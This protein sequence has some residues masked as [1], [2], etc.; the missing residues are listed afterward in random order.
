ML[1]YLLLK[2]LENDVFSYTISSNKGKSIKAL[3]E[4]LLEITNYLALSFNEL[5]M[6]QKTSVVL[7]QVTEVSN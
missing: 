2:H 7:F 1:I 6:D 5:T 3:S 4:Q